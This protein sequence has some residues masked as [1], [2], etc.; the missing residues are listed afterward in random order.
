[1]L[2]RLRQTA[3]QLDLPFGDRKHTYNSR[4]AQELGKW[5]ETLGRGD[6][7]HMAAF[8]AY[9]AQ[10][11]NIARIPVLE[12]IVHKVGLPRNTVQGVLADGEFRDAVDRDWQRSCQ[13]GVRAVPTFRLNG[14][15]LVGAQDDAALA[16]MLAAGGVLRRG[17]K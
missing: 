13:L 4:R 8:Q 17:S 16:R 11:E 5:A 2:A 3:A 9:F 1:M 10:G 14:S 12:E 15:T 6:Q 7:F